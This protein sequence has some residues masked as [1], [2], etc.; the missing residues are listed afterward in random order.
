V[1]DVVSWGGG[2]KQYQVTIDP[3]RLRAYNLSLKQ[4]YD[5]IASNNAN[6]GGSYIP[7]GQYAVTVRGIGLLQSTS[8]IADVC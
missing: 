5:A 2:I 8:D 7:R 1:A 4:V 3:G 6:A